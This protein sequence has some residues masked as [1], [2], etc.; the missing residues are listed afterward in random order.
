MFWLLFL[1]FSGFLF[2]FLLSGLSGLPLFL[3]FLYASFGVDKDLFAREE[4]MALGANLDFEFWL[5]GT[6]GKGVPAGTGDL[7]LRIV[8]RV[9]LF[10]SHNRN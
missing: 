6:D 3:K 5:G 1:C 7:C 10:F 4:R 8:F 9:K 2:P